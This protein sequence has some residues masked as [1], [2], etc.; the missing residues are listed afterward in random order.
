MTYADATSNYDFFDPQ[1][2]M[3]DGL[4]TFDYGPGGLGSVVALEGPS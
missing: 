1:A 2:W 3:L 4:V